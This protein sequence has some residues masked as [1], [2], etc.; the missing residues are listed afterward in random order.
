MG[1]RG[2]KKLFIYDPVSLEHINTVNVGRISR[3]MFSSSGNV[4]YT[5]SNDKVG[6]LCS[7]TGDIIKECSM[8]LPYLLSTS[9][10]K[11]MYLQ[12]DKWA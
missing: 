10:D 2:S 9:F 5:S 11:V 1:S 4:V 12:S 7:K 6:V 3:A 8:N